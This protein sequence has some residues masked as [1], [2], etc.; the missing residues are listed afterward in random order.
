MNRYHFDRPRAGQFFASTGDPM[1]NSS[2]RE[3]V[4]ELCELNVKYL[5]ALL[6]SLSKMYLV[7]WS[8][9]YHRQLVTAISTN[10]LERTILS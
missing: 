9:A 3:M 6:S 8:G 10:I 2:F 7:P 1:D 5:Q 4:E